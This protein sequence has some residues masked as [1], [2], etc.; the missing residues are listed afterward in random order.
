MPVCRARSRDCYIALG[1]VVK[2]RFQARC[3][4]IML[5][6]LR[7]HPASAATLD[8]E[9]SFTTTVYDILSGHEIASTH[10]AFAVSV[11][12]SLW[13]AK[14][15]TDLDKVDYF[16]AGTDG[17]HC[18]LL[19]AFPGHLPRLPASEQPG[20]NVA[21]AKIIS[22]EIPYFQEVTYL[23]LLWFAFASSD[24]LDKAPNGFFRPIAI[25]IPDPFEIA[26]TDHV[27][28]YQGDRFSGA[29]QLPK[30]GRFW[31]DGN[32]RRFDKGQNYMNAT[33]AKRPYPKPYNTGFLAGSYE[34][35]AHTNLDGVTIP[36][37]FQYRSYFP[38]NGGLSTNDLTVMRETLFTV[39]NIAASRTIRSSYLPAMVGPTHVLDYRFV[40]SD[41]QVP[42][43]H[44]P[45]ETRWLGKDEVMKLQQYAVAFGRRDAWL[46]K[47]TSYVNKTIGGTIVLVTLAL[48]LLVW[49]QRL[50]K[51]RVPNAM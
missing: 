35:T 10:G 31:S 14:I 3:L 34:C 39:T 8:A 46:Y 24:A 25:E 51:R 26:Y 9:G 36:T 1:V 32:M 33:P 40:R 17:S 48:P 42:A 29:I 50:R 23:P 37:E 41:P 44:Y 15:I 47:R 4:F 45:I 13:C 21:S 43:F 28:P 19:V 27:V 49:M 18:Y 38:K 6:L 2:R 22:G 20:N 16:E 12:N 11:S 5:T 30:R 7:W